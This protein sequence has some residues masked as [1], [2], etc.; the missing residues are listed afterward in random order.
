MHPLVPERMPFLIHKYA[1]TYLY[2]Q[3]FV[4]NYKFCFFYC[5]SIYSSPKLTCTK[6][7][8]CMDTQAC[9]KSLV[10]L[11]FGSFYSYGC[12]AL[13]GCFSSIVSFKCT[14]YLHMHR[15]ECI[16]R[17]ARTHSHAHAHTNI[18]TLSHSHRP[19]CNLF[20]WQ[21]ISHRRGLADGGLGEMIRLWS[22][23]RKQRCR[24]TRVKWS[25]VQEPADQQWAESAHD[26]S[27][28]IC[29]RRG[30]CGVAGE[31]ARSPSFLSFPHG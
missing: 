6:K 15:E 9:T 28:E 31:G 23:R 24:K 16:R 25:R 30:S 21:P 1:L 4:D 18:H 29:L 14:Q 7:N 8:A 26:G 27:K 11:Q 17:Y 19:F 2:L 20:S 10:R 22:G 3:S 13:G 5:V 12:I